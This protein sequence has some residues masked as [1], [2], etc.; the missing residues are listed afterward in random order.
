[1]ENML[2][3]APTSRVPLDCF[4][5][6]RDQLPPAMSPAVVS[7]P[8]IDMRRG[9]DEV[10]R[11][12][13]DAGKEFGFFQASPRI[14][15]QVVGHGVPE[16]VL[17]DME[18]VCEEFFLLPAPD[19]AEFYS[20]DKAK[21][22]RLFSG[23]TYETG[24]DKYWRDC[25]RLACPFPVVAS[26]TTKGDWPDKPQRLREVVEK[27][28]VLARRVGMEL[29]RLLCE[30]MGLQPDIFVGDISG[31]DVI[32][33]IN[34]YPPCP[35]PRTMLGLPPHCDRNLIT[36]LLPGAVHGLDVAYKGDWI[37]VEPVPNAIV[38]NFGQQLE[39][40]S[41][42][43]LKSI[44][45][46]ATTNSVKARTSV[47]TF[48]MPTPDCLIGPA[49]EF[50]GEDNPPYYRTVKFRDFVR[51]YNVVKLGSGLNLTTNLR[52]VQKEISSK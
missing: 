52:N 20:E 1:M 51:T 29:L 14:N 40:V 28:I 34:R 45:H 13:L 47:A 9:R 32:I 31:G 5:L 26:D 35:S 50:V 44:E 2:H 33:N 8:V 19:K 22:N 38:V 21:R 23:A 18:A 25:L 17:R 27:F 24:G 7:L 42:G 6:P 41:N 43:M 15:K 3:L 4:V 30:A 37:K 48:I 16:Q 46:R 49:E 36:L 11:A 12:V 10:R 39:V